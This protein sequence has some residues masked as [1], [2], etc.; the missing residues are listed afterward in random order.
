MDIEKLL[1]SFEKLFYNIVVLVVL[2]PITL[3]KLFRGYKMPAQ[4]IDEEFGKTPDERFKKYVSPVL[5]VVICCI[6]PLVFFQDYKL[7]VDKN[8]TDYSMG[9]SFLGRTLFLAVSVNFFPLLS[10]VYVLVVQKKQITA[11][12]LA[13]PYY[14][15][16]YS[17]SYT[18]ILIGL[19]FSVI[20]LFDLF[21]R[22]AG[23]QQ[24]IGNWIDVVFSIGGAVTWV[25]SFLSVFY[26]FRH[27]GHFSNW[28]ALF[29]TVMVTVMIFT[30]AHYFAPPV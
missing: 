13:K 15:F 29:S 5:L 12:N 9:M 2:I 4:I 14:A 28:R 17:F 18:L 23:E 19:V 6:L 24:Q 16:V 21:S 22:A 10:A 7:S 27:T 11:D 1:S 20:V 3:F 26:T 25:L 30:A 8:A